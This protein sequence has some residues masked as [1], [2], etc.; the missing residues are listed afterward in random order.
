MP[1][2]EKVN[3]G[4]PKFIGYLALVLSCLG[5]GAS[6]LSL[7]TSIYLL[8]H[9]PK[10]TNVS[11]TAVKNETTQTALER[12]KETGVMRV[13][14]GGF[15]PYTIVDPNEAD[16]NKRMQGFVVDMVNEIAKRYSPPLN[17]EWYNLNWETF[18]ADMLS[19]RFDFLADAVY[20]TIPKAADFGM[21]DPFSYFGI[22]V[23]VVRI[24]DNRFKNFHDLDRD[25]ITISLAQGYVSTDY[26]QQE[27]SKPKFKIITVGKDA[28]AQLDEVLLGRAD[29]ALNDTPTVIQYVRAHPDKVKALWLASPPS[30]VAAGFVTRREDSDLLEFLNISIR[31]LKI[32]GTLNRLDNKW[33][34]L[35]NF[36]ELKLVPGAGLATPVKK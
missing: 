12:I 15:P 27:L 32:D 1:L 5:I 19:N 4:A 18:R 6:I 17:V 34:S 24:D 2:T 3:S 8:M 26:A 33:Q 30:A 9:A 29:I 11:S 25:D 14:Y 31:I 7:G 28:F 21:T 13:G 36:E 35:G 22:A 20:E 23:G 16:P 10:F